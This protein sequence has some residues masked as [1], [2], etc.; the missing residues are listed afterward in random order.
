MGADVIGYALDPPSNPNMFEAIGLESQIT[1]IHGDVCDFNQLLSV[2]ETHHPEIVFHLAAQSLVRKSYQ[3]PRM[4]YETNVMGTVN[5]FEAV[6]LSNSTCVVINVT[7]DKCYENREWVWGYREN[8]PMGGHDPYSS[9]K[10]C[11]ELVTAAYIK[12]F[13]APQKFGVDHHVALATVRAGNVIGGGD[14]GLDRLV[15]DCMRA[16]ASGEDILI[17]N[18]R[19][20]RPWQ[21]VLEPLRGYIMLAEKLWDSGAEFCGPWNFGPNDQNGWTVEMVVKRLIELWGDGN[22]TC[23]SG[24]QAHEARSLNLYSTKAAALLGWTPMMDT[25]QALSLT[26]DWYKKFYGRLNWQDLA[27]FTSEQIRENLQ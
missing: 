7:S 3:E 14:W 24:N 27:V 10:G 15:P 22:Y 1:H 2:F 13:F 4:T 25:G 9:S 5:L 20:L 21:H 23:Q 18:P 16:L 8:D 17:R 26:V 12:S 11:S 19:S 6:R